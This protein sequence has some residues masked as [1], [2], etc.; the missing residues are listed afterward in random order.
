MI[1]QRCREK[2]HAGCLTSDC[3]CGH[4]DSGVRPLTDAERQDVRAGRLVANVMPR[5]TTPSAEADR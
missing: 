2:S 4:A 5:D 3:T 1:C